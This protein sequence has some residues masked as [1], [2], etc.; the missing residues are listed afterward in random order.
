MSEV[1][2]DF[3]DRSY[4]DLFSHPEMIK[5]LL[6]G[7]VQEDFIEDIDF[8]DFQKVGTTYILEEYQ[9]RE[10]DLIIRLNLK[11]QEAYL[12][13]LIE[14]Q[15]TPDKYIALRVLEYLLTFYQDLLKQKKDLPDKLPS[16]F[17]IVLYTGKD[18]FNCAVSLEELI[19][20]PYKRLMKYVPRFEYYKI[21]INEINEGKY[22]ELIGLENIVA[23]CFNL[24]RAEKK[25]KTLEAFERLVEISKEHRD[26]LIRA[27]EMWLRQFFKRKGI[28][29][30]EI[31]LSGGRTMIEDVIDQIYEE[32]IVKGKQEGILE[33][34]EKGKLDMVKKLLKK[35][36]SIEELADIAEVQVEELKKAL[37]E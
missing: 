31:S 4:K 27:I 36:F 5:D 23:A 17:P 33:G 18:P 10:T 28:E 29:V 30:G 9:K 14:L 26:Y 37:A 32:G 2:H 16:V 1:L 24:V 19:D 25:E 12:Y 22:G 11:G 21:A 35:G 34:V 8:S 3:H 7:F 13:I 20:K 15:S 6:T